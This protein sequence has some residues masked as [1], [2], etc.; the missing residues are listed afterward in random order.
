MSFFFPSP[1]SKR[2][3]GALQLL[4]FEKEEDILH[5][6]YRKGIKRRSGGGLSYCMQQTL[7]VLPPSSKRHCRTWLLTWKPCFLGKKVDYIQVYP[8]TQ[9]PDLS[10]TGNWRAK[11]ILNFI[12]KSNE[13][14]ISRDISCRPLQEAVLVEIHT[15]EIH[16]IDTIYA[17]ILSRVKQIPGQICSNSTEICSWKDGPWLSFLYFLCTTPVC[18]MHAVRKYMNKFFPCCTK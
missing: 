1:S 4:A 13:E 9:A 6:F 16:F 7:A 2:K 5:F 10:S 15:N 3:E 12:E 8:D 14:D 17:D 11:I 18:L